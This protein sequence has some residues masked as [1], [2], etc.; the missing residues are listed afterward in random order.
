IRK[1]EALCAVGLVKRFAGPAFLKEQL[2]VDPADFRF[3]DTLTI[4]AAE[5]LREAEIDWRDDY[6]VPWNGH[7]L[8]WSK[9]DQNLEDADPCPEDLWKRIKEAREKFG[10]PPIYYAI[11]KLD[12]DDLGGWLRGEKSPKVR[13]V[14]HPDLVKYYE[15]LASDGATNGLNAKRPV[16]PGLHA[17]ISTALA[18]FS[19]H[20]VPEIVERHHGR[21]IYSGGDDTLVL[22]PVSQA[23]PCALELYKAYTTDWYT[24]DKKNDDEERD[25][26][27]Y[28]MMGSR[29]TLSGG[30]VI[31]HAKDDL[32]LALRD[33][34]RAEKK[35][36]EMDRD[37]LVITVCRRSGEQT[38]VFCPW[39][40]AETVNGWVDAFNQ[41]AS[42]RWTYHLKAEEP[43]LQG[44]DINAIRAEIGRQI[45]RAELATRCLLAKQDKPERAG[46]KLVSSFDQYHKEVMV[47]RE[48]NVPSAFNN[49]INLC[50]TASFI[51]RGRDV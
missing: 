22:L 51:A 44:L 27:E 4:A 36:K 38:D 49:W 3:Q 20:A 24:P 41:G 39:N 48:F 43:T 9:R 40:F 31:V 15:K 37:A 29:A 25:K 13:E 8:H 16:S 7:W 19:L 35:A 6:G 34:R 45:N 47:R 5:W 2:K 1:G 32:R 28:M 50:Q 46:D 42:D 21:T 17:A 30:L 11:L 18:N 10:C 26:N 23:L 14:M 33:A 12:G